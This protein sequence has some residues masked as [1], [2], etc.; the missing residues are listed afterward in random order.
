MDTDGYNKKQILVR[1]DVEK[2]KPPYIAGISVKWCGYCENSQAVSQKVK[3]KITIQLSNWTSG[4]ILKR[5][6]NY[7]PPKLVHDY[8]S[9]IHNTLKVE[10]SEVFVS[11]WMDF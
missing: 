3:R 7:V 2:L 8:G 5:N 4:R 9:I 1:R 10:T 6:E 11:W